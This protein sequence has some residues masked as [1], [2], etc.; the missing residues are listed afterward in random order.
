MHLWCAPLGFAVWYSIWVPRGCC[1][2]K[3]V[4][5]P[6]ILQTLAPILQIPAP[7]MG[8]SQCNPVLACF[9]PPMH[10]HGNHGSSWCLGN[11]KCTRDAQKLPKSHQNACRL[12][13]MSLHFLLLE[14][15]NDIGEIPLLA[16]VTHSRLAHLHTTFLAPLEQLIMVGW[17]WLWD[18]SMSA[19][20]AHLYL[21]LLGKVCKTTKFADLAAICIHDGA[22]R[23]LMWVGLSHVNS[24][25]E[26]YR[27]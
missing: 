7:T 1:T 15:C 11:P 19:V 9:C 27:Y 22:A 23:A 2:Q 3:Q 13:Q 18:F 6:G 16:M 20:F 10:A 8:A 4:Q 24:I 14:K 21:K 25:N 12:L 26:R 17:S 5:E